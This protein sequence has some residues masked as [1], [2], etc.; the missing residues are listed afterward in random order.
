M[1]YATS[2]F[3]PLVGALIAGLL[4]PALGD[5]AAERVAILGMVVSAICGV[6]VMGHVAFEGAPYV[7]IPIV[8]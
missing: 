8:D 7:S 1:L 2:V 6:I 5:R 4:G 3:A